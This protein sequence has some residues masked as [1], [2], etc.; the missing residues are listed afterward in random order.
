MSVHY[1]FKSTLDYDTITFDGLHI[2]VADL[3]KA[4]LQQKR[5]SKITDFDL[6]IINAQTKEEYPHDTSLIP[7]N[8]SLIISRVPLTNQAKKSWDTANKPIQPRI[9]PKPVEKTDF[10]LSKMEG[11]EEEKIQAMMM[12]STAEYDPKSYQ[13]IRG[14]SQTG[15]VPPTYRCN[16]CKKGGHWIKNCPFNISKEHTEV[17]RTT[18]IPK[19]FIDKD[20][21]ALMIESQEPL[22]EE[23][24]KQEIP[25]DLVCG[26]C[27]D[28]FVDAVMIPCC[29]SSFCDDCV[30]TALLESEDNECPDCKEKGSSP[31]SLIPNRFLRNSVNA[32]KNRTGYKASSQTKKEI[33]IDPPP[34]A[35]TAAA[36]TEDDN[37]NVAEEK[38]QLDV[39]KKT[40]PKEEAKE[41]QPEEEERRDNNEITKAVSDNEPKELDIKTKDEHVDVP[42]TDVKEEKNEQHHHV[43]PTH[44][45]PAHE[46][47]DYEDNIVVKVPSASDTRTEKYLSRRHASS[48][49]KP[50]GLEPHSPK[51]KPQYPQQE[52]N[53]H[54]SHDRPSSKDW[55]RSPRDHETPT[56]DHYGY[57]KNSRPISTTKPPLEN[58][59]PP[60]A[61]PG[62]VQVPPLYPPHQGGYDMQQRPIRPMNMHGGYHN[63]M[64]RPPLYPHPNMP[65]HPHPQVGPPPLRMPIAAMGSYDQPPYNPMGNVVPGYQRFPTANMPNRFNYPVREHENP[66]QMR[67]F[68]SIASVYEVVQA[69]VGS[70]I[71]DDPLEAFNRIMKEKEKKK[72]EDRR[73]PDRRRRSKERHIRGNFRTSPYNNRNSKDHGGGGGGG[74]NNNSSGGGGGGYHDKRGRSRDRDNDRRWPR[75]EKPGDKERDRERDRDRERE[76]ERDRN[77]DHLYRNSRRS[78]SLERNS[79]SRSHSP[80]NKRYR[81]PSN[82]KS[83]FNQDKHPHHYH[84]KSRPEDHEDTMHSN[85]HKREGSRGRHISKPFEPK[86]MLNDDRMGDMRKHYNMNDENSEPPPPGF[87]IQTSRNPFHSN[88]SASPSTNLREI[89]RNPTPDLY[90]KCVSQDLEEN[91]LYSSN[92]G[93]RSER[94]LRS[95]SRSRTRSRS[96]SSVRAAEKRRKMQRS[97][98]PKGKPASSTSD[99]HHK[100]DKERGSSSHRKHKSVD[101]YHPQKDKEYHDHDFDSKRRSMTPPRQKESSSNVN[102]HKIVSGGE[103]PSSPEEKSE[104]KSEKKLKERKKKR[105]DKSEKKK[106]KKEKKSKKER[107]RNKSED[108]HNDDAANEE[109]DEEDQQQR[110]DEEHQGEHDD[111]QRGGHAKEANDSK[112]SNEELKS[113][114]KEFHLY[115]DLEEEGEYRSVEKELQPNSTPK[116]NNTASPP[117]RMEVVTPKQMKSLDYGDKTPPSSDIKCFDAVLDIH[118]YETDF[119][120]SFK[121]QDSGNNK[122]VAPETSKWELDDNLNSMGGA[123]GG[124]PDH[125]GEDKNDDNYAHNNNNNGDSKV[126]NEVIVRAEKAIFARAINAIRPIELHKKS[127]SKERSS[128]SKNYPDDHDNIRNIKITLPVNI[129]NERSVE[130]RGGGGGSEGS[131]EKKK[132]IK[133]RLGSKVQ[134]P[135][136]YEH[137]D[138]HSRRGLSESKSSKKLGDNEKNSRER[139]REAGRGDRDR[140]RRD[141]E[142]EREREK[143]RERERDREKDRERE[144]ERERE[145]DKERERERERE[146]EKEKEREREKERNKERE[147]LKQRDSGG[148]DRERERDRDRERERNHDY[149]KDQQRNKDCKPKEKSD[150]NHHPQRDNDGP[151]M[152]SQKRHHHSPVSRKRS[153]STSSSDSEDSDVERKRKHAKTD[154]KSRKRSESP[155]SDSKRSSKKKAKSDKKK[156]KKSKK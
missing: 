56:T 78:K 2:S 121:Y 127:S 148:R 66:N 153:P 7:K 30:R 131:G 49:P 64:H 43:A 20:E 144:R 151:A 68:N 88:I 140:E 76:R 101:R 61:A 134:Q 132:S 47:S 23:E 75:Y 8:T 81:S 118:E 116:N 92:T 102:E 9:V 91:K 48:H 98:T 82:H 29:G 85:R 73:S 35:A 129:S 84:P 36:A 108:R 149:D 96:R 110:R 13:K 126:T 45:S 10:D 55:D 17:K 70:G 115:D 11:S 146:R 106:V 123:A 54:R 19:S 14:F 69:K 62:S 89:R 95:R 93:N 137:N 104:K 16:K 6:Q 53:S 33:K 80:P 27:N 111:Q 63:H 34:P 28:L 105:K 46:D 25:E 50:P 59:P 74:G 86:G 100:K 97:T 128:S 103:H 24:K 120:E 139:D 52:S 119:D 147:R 60:G 141:R 135:P 12:Q 51:S 40:E 133:D 125:M 152:S 67:P 145:R 122:L 94:D 5:L 138:R 1:K 26:I 114:D 107:H 44:S 83:H 41:Q 65:P 4:I 155:D 124:G 72:T 18:G 150:K 38:P 99:H 57:E 32:F 3:K 156:K 58:I 143:E 77:K 113:S 154:K 31:G 22:L 21:R 71:I 79:R 87:E 90:E 142:R 37:D 136:S 130:V 109:E 112:N 15:E 42:S 39:I 117:P